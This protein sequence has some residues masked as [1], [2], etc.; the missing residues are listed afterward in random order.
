MITF[1][2]FKSHRTTSL[3]LNLKVFK[4]LKI[5]HFVQGNDTN[6]FAWILS[7]EYQVF[8]YKTMYCE[9]PCILKS[10]P[11]FRGSDTEIVKMELVKERDMQSWHWCP[12]VHPL[13]HAAAWPCGKTALE[14]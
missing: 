2:V 1:L 12:M 6:Q 13:P 8:Y 9:L 10:I 3:P 7:R 14:S 5:V 11:P 4:N